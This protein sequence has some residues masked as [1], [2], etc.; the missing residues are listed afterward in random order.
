[1]ISM[2]QYCFMVNRLYGNIHIR[3]NYE[4]LFLKNV[5]NLEYKIE[6]VIKG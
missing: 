1:M 2:M 6:F 3:S 5:V 4:L